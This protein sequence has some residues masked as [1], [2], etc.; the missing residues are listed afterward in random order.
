[1]IAYVLMMHLL[2]KFLM[3]LGLSLCEDSP[4]TAGDGAHLR[5]VVIG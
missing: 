2:L 1:M 3:C 5:T 4:S